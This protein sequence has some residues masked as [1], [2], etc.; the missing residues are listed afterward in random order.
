[1]CMVSLP[2]LQPP[3]ERPSEYC[4]PVDRQGYTRGD[5]MSWKLLLRLNIRFLDV[6]FVFVGSNGHVDRLSASSSSLEPPMT[7]AFA[8]DPT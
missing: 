2:P 8:L 6:L 3:S 7:T 4:Y 5:T 1:M